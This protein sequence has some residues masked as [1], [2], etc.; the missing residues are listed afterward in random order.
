MPHPRQPDRL[1]AVARRGALHVADADELVVRRAHHEHGGPLGAQPAA[2]Q[3]LVLR[4]RRLASGAVDVALGRL[5]VE[6]DEEGV[7]VEGQRATHHHRGD[8]AGVARQ[9]REHGAEHAVRRGGGEQHE[10]A[11]GVAVGH[12]LAQQS[13]HRVAHEHRRRGQL[14]DRLQDVVHVVAHEGAAEALAAPAAAVATQRQRVR[15]EAALGRSTQPVLR[16]APGA[17]AD[18]VDEQQRRS[19]GVV[20]RERHEHLAVRGRLGRHRPVP[21]PHDPRAPAHRAPSSSCR[22]ASSAAR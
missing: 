14:G 10:A 16:E 6:P 2:A 15:R 13:A 18:A 4:Q 22:A 20:V 19:G 7:G 9:G 17:M 8:V 3:Q 21:G 11:R 5:G 1:D 12:Q